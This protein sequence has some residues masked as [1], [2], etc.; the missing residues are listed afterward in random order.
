MEKP[1]CTPPENPDLE[2]LI[3]IISETAENLKQRKREKRNVLAEQDNVRNSLLAIVPDDI[4]GLNHDPSLLTETEEQTEL[5][6]LENLLSQTV[7]PLNQLRKNAEKNPTQINTYLDHLIKLREITENVEISV[8]G[9]GMRDLSVIGAILTLKKNHIYGRTWIGAS[10][11]SLIAAFGATTGGFRRLSEEEILKLTKKVIEADPFH[12]ATLNPQKIKSNVSPLNLFRHEGIFNKNNL[13]KM[14]DDFFGTIKLADIKGCE[15]IILATD[16]QTGQ[17][18]LLTN[19]DTHNNTLADAVEA[20]CSIPGAFTPASARLSGRETLLTDASV[21]ADFLRTVIRNSDLGLQIN[22]NFGNDFFNHLQA[23]GKEELIS[24]YK[25]SAK[26]YQKLSSTFPARKLFNHLHQ[27][28]P[29]ITLT[30]LG[31]NLHHLICNLG[32]R[33][34]SDEERILISPKGLTLLDFI[35]ANEKIAEAM[36]EKGK[37]AAEAKIDEIKNCLPVLQL[38]LNKLDLPEGNIFNEIR[39]C[40]EQLKTSP[41]PSSQTRPTA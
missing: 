40:R 34:L 24:L 1:T 18:V 6:N 28:D 16:R 41:L 14:L 22:I 13:R 27:I 35:Y 8:S 37:K 31:W 10:A 29:K 4:F 20:S 30:T 26:L 39:W 38:V 11:G 9:G 5:K 17:Q 36:I 15:L 32:D 25:N 2:Q 19:H 23:P 21:S 7:S 33:V 3:A 12:L